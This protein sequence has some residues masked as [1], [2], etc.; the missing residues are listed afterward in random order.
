MANSE[1]STEVSTV[2]VSTQSQPKEQWGW[3]VLDSERE[4][5]RKR[6]ICVGWSVGDLDEIAAGVAVDHHIDSF[7]DGTYLDAFLPTLQS[8]ISIAEGLANG[9]AEDFADS[10]SEP[11][12]TEFRNKFIALLGETLALYTNTVASSVRFS[13]EGLNRPFEIIGND[14]AMLKK[15]RELTVLIRDFGRQVWPDRSLSWL[16]EKP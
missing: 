9:R 11:G 2:S 3:Q 13:P 14:L 5:T 7:F 10:P 15:Y 1:V 12:L 4:R 6:E 16:Y 8:W